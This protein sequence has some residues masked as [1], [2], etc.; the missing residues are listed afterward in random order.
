M[1]KS[2]SKAELIKRIVQGIKDMNHENYFKNINRFSYMKPE[3]KIA[4][5][6]E[7]RDKLNQAFGYADA[8]MDVTNMIEALV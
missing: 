3:D 6:A 7:D 1:A 5:S 4:I 8:L 2:L